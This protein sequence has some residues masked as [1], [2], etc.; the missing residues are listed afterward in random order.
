MIQYISL[1]LVILSFGFSL[2]FRDIFT[3]FIFALSLSFLILVEILS[4]KIKKFSERIMGIEKKFEEIN[5]ID[6]KISNLQKN[7]PFLG[8]MKR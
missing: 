6:E 5:K 2:F 1:A 7:L 8:G 4:G 3:L